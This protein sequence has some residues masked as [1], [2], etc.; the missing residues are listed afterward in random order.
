MIYEAN[1][2][3]DKLF[4]NDYVLKIKTYLLKIFLELLVELG[5]LANEIGVLN[6]EF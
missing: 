2:E 3:L 5:E 6:I 1:K 4:A